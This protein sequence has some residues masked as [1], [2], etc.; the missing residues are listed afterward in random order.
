[1]K[2]REINNYKYELMETLTES[3][4]IS[5]NAL[6]EFIELDRGLL[7]IR[8]GYCWDGASGPTIDTKST[9][10]GSLVHDALYQLMRM[11]KIGQEYKPLAD[12]TF[13]RLIRADGMGVFRAWYYYNG[14]RFFGRKAAAVQQREPK[15]IEV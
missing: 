8:E 13:R 7:T 14:V 5:A 10:R 1:M 15:I 2:Y 3:V 11:G 4:P 12:Q 9:M 6:T